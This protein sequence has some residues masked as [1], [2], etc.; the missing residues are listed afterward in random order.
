MKIRLRLTWFHDGT[1]EGQVAQQCAAPKRES[2]LTQMQDDDTA[3]V[4]A[5]TK[6]FFGGSKGVLYGFP[7]AAAATFSSSTSPSRAAPQGSK[8]VSCVECGMK[9]KHKV[10]Y[11]FDLWKNYHD[12]SE[13]GASFPSRKP[14]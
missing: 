12:K 7:R 5:H 3:V 13:V 8:C 2:H 6:H 14:G 9:K 4:E 10:G 1:S 11:L